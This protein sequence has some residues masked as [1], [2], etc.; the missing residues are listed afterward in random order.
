MTRILWLAAFALGCASSSDTAATDGGQAGSGHAG[1]IDTA[2]VDWDAVSC[3]E[4]PVLTWDNFGAGFMRHYCQ[5]CHA[6]G[7]ADRYGA[8]EAVT[9]DTVDETW[10][11]RDRV[12]ARSVGDDPD[13]PPAGG[14]TEDDRIRLRLWLDCAPEGT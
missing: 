8:P 5:G 12:L 14:T 11:W 7:V 13:M 6:S 4:A 10:A 9:F 2:S 1:G 3:E